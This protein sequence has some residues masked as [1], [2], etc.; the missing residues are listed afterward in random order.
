MYLCVHT[1]SSGGAGTERKSR[2]LS[3]C[4]AQSRR[5]D[6]GRECIG[7]HLYIYMYIYI[8]AFPEGRGL[9]RRGMMEFANHPALHFSPL[10]S[11][12]SHLRAHLKP[13]PR[14]HLYPLVPPPPPPPLALPSS[15]ILFISLL[16]ISFLP[17]F[18]F[19]SDDIFQ[20]LRLSRFTVTLLFPCFFL[21]S[22]SLSPRRVT[23]SSSTPLPPLPRS[24]YIIQPLFSFPPPLIPLS[25]LHALPRLLPRPRYH[26]PP[27]RPSTPRGAPALHTHGAK[28]VLVNPGWF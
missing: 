5:H 2:K 24:A 8:P 4:R 25:L 12:F 9:M 26:P 28:R 22:S 27:P 11:R 7:I 15:L 18:V 23:S 21:S 19:L 14:F 20:T 17:P 6:G 10:G 1:N 16:D 13:H 3:F